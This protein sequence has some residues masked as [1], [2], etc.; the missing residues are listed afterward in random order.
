[1]LFILDQMDYTIDLRSWGFDLYTLNKTIRA[2][3]RSWGGI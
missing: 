3:L 2:Y 1:M